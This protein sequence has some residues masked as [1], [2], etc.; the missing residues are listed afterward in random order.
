MKC[1]N[2]RTKVTSV[3]PLRAS[4]WLST[5]YGTLSA[6]FILQQQG[7]YHYARELSRTSTVFAM[8]S[9]LSRSSYLQEHDFDSGPSSTWCL[10][11]VFIFMSLLLLRQLVEIVAAPNYSGDSSEPRQLDVP[12]MHP[13]SLADMLPVCMRV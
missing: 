12:S 2:S 8:S 11:A 1:V 7:L 5:R 10:A 3:S 6:V 9:T 13:H 4:L